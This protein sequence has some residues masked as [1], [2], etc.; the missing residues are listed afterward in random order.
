MHGFQNFPTDF[1]DINFL[2][3]QK[4][5]QLYS[6]LSHG[7]A[8]HTSWDHKDNVLI[9]MFGA[10]LGMDYLEKHVTTNYGEN[11]VDWQAAISIEMFNDL[12]DK[13]KLLKACNGDGLLKL[14]PGEEAYSVFGANKKAAILN[15][16]II[17]SHEL[18]ID[19]FSFKR[20]GQSSDL[21]QLDVLAKKGNKIKKDLMKGHC[22]LIEDFE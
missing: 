3:I 22:L 14:N 18:S 7:Y 4:L 10:A 15:K 9:T 20:T 19:D 13:V 16:N 21:S 5:L 12:S 6:N 11:R 17:A 1:K 8:D 2:K